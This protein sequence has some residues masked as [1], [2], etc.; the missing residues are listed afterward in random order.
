MKSQ[1]RRLQR[2]VKTSSAKQLMDYSL[3]HM[4]AFELIKEHFSQYG[5]GPTYRELTTAM[6]YK[7]IE[8]IRNTV[9]TLD[10]LNY[11]N[12]LGGKR[13]MMSMPKAYHIPVYCSDEHDGKK[14]ELL[15]VDTGLYP[16]PPH[17]AIRL[18]SDFDRI[19]SKGTLIVVHKPLVAN[20]GN[21]AAV[22]KNEQVSF[23]P[24][25]TPQKLDSVFDGVVVGLIA[26]FD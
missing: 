7:S 19:G 21:T 13:R 24:V 10:D 1:L 25:Q 16:R 26:R 14:Q 3:K 18:T 12:L 20:P 9:D 6:G 22:W 17:Y 2:R 15:L 23:S 8:S 11:L 5:R 4:R